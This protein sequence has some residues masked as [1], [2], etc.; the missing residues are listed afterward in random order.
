[1]SRIRGPGTTRNTEDKASPC[2]VPANTCVVPAY[3]RTNRDQS[4][5]AGAAPSYPPTPLEMLCRSE[6]KRLRTVII[7]TIIT[8]DMTRYYMSCSGCRDRGRVGLITPEDI[9]ERLMAVRPSNIILIL[10]LILI[11][12]S[13][14]S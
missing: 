4:Q 1:M 5:A 13:L 14:F 9:S 8:W 7:T 2:V 11:L 6:L 10:I 3:T 12:N